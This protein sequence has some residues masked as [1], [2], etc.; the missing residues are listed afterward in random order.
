MVNITPAG[1]PV[2]T[3]EDTVQV[4]GH[5]CDPEGR[6][7][8]AFGPAHVEGLTVGTEHDPGQVRLT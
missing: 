6:G 1:G 3:G 4:S 2:A 5:D 8:Q 7:D